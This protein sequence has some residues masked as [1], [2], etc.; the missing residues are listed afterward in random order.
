MRKITPSKGGSEKSLL[1]L[2]GKKMKEI[3]NMN[4]AT[5]FLGKGDRLSR[6]PR[7]SCRMF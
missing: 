3:E 2:L 1:F 5:I 4:Q 6:D 7:E